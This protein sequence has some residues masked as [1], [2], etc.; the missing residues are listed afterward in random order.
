MNNSTYYDHIFKVLIIGDSSVGKT[1]FLLRY[2]DDTF[3]DN[4]ISTIGL[5]YKL[6]M[7]DIDNK[8]IKMQIWDTAGQDRF[9]AITK[10]YYKG[11]HG[12]ILMFD[13]TSQDSFNNIKN[14]LTQIKD[15]TNE[16]IKIILVGNKCDA[17]NRRVIDK[18]K[19]EKLAKDFDLKYIEASAKDNLNVNETFIFLSKEIYNVMEK[20]SKNEFGLSKG[21]KKSKCCKG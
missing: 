6:K 13:L 18:E 3:V 1:C 8:L 16:K 7:L 15:N 2:S 11:S 5:D 20:N 14:W 12:I 21:K 4:H 10:N 17:I 9:R 19:A